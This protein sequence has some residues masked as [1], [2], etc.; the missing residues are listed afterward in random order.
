MV[1][2]YISLEAKIA[3]NKALYYDA[4]EQSQAGWHEGEDDPTP[5]VKYL[6]GTI[7]SAYR[8]FEERMEIVGDKD[9]AMDI[10]ARAVAT[11]IGKFTKADI[12][13]LCP[14]ISTSS[15]EGSL[16]MMARSGAITKHGDGRGT[17]YTRND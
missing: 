2:K 5:F 4:L 3:K 1:G 8:D 16:K 9:S 13:A 10:V 7:I 12:V 6:L 14:S 11:R 15:V 17:F